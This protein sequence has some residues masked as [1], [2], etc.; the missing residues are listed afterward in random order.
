MNEVSQNFSEWTSIH[1]QSTERYHPELL[2]IVQSVYK[3]ASNRRNLILNPILEFGRL[4]TTTYELCTCPFLLVE[5]L[6]K[7]VLG[8]SEEIPEFGRDILHSFHEFDNSPSVT[9]LRA[10][11]VCF[12]CKNKTPEGR[13]TK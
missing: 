6:Q 5:D 1:D 11:A 8:V 7:L 13:D 3:W 10:R 9:P 4:A 12:I 2:G